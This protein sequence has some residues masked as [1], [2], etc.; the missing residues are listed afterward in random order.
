MINTV[1]QNKYCTGCSACAHICPTGAIQ[2]RENDRG[3]L[4]PQVDASR[5]TDC[6]LCDRV[7]PVY[8]HKTNEFIRCYALKLA[9]PAS[10]SR[11]Q[12]GGAFYA[13]ASHVLQAGGVVYGVS[14][15]ELNNVQTIRIDRHED[16]N[17]ILKSKYVQSDCF[18]SF[19]LVKTDLENGLFV[20][21]SG[22]ACV[23]Q[24]LKNYLTTK[25]IPVDKLL[26]CDLICHGVP[27]RLVDRDFIARMGKI[28]HSNVTEL[29]YRDKTLGW[30]SHMEKYTFE[31]G[32]CVYTNE[33]V[34]PFSKGFLLSPACFKCQYTSPYRDSDITIGDFWTLEKLG[35]SK[36]QFKTGLSVC[37]VRNRI[38]DDLLTELA[39]KHVIEFSEIALEEAMQ[40][41]LEKPSSKPERYDK[42]WKKYLYNRFRTLWP[43]YYV[44]S[45]KE[46][47]RRILK[48]C[49][50]RNFKH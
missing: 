10:L 24:G 49:L 27:S 18:D 40:W 13:V 38:I 43:V 36:S 6:G 15:R 47:I 41:N 26:T 17:Y 29:I 35:M 30:G 16:L 1:V 48:K 39:E 2:L 21:Y 42:F 3:F 19:D 45:P 23:I 9:S 8:E 44:L 31:N 22:T 7:C 32:K 20:L 34:I 50:L 37:I 25:H 14:N 33:K 4:T 5:C 12:S 28:H 46:R 11:T